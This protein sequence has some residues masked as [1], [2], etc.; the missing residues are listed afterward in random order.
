[1]PSTTVEG[2]GFLSGISA[3]T[4]STGSLIKGKFTSTGSCKY[5]TVPVI[6]HDPMRT[7][8][9]CEGKAPCIL[10]VTSRYRWVVN[11]MLLLLYTRRWKRVLCEISGSHSIKYGDCG[12]LGYGAVYRGVF[13]L[14]HRPDGGLSMTTLTVNVNIVNDMLPLYHCQPM[15]SPMMYCLSPLL[16][17]IQIKSFAVHHQNVAFSEILLL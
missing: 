9:K 1:V 10:N 14:H 4:W 15:M 5:K 2:V 17:H 13:C 3:A 16:P 12:F 8:R 6:K 11:F 7:N